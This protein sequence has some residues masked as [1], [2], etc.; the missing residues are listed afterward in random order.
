ML[1][2][3][4]RVAVIEGI[5]TLLLFLVA[6][7]LKYLFGQPG[8]IPLAGWA[9]GI[10]FIAYAVTM[11]LGL[12]GHGFTLLQWLRTVLAAFVPFGTFL[13]DPML[14]RRQVAPRK[15]AASSS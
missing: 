2:L 15:A 10:A 12:W 6:M 11:P 4:R 8:L 9:H 7:P 14:E 1:K 13:N 3:F 5:T